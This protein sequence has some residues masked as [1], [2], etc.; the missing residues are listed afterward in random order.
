M[1]GGGGKNERFKKQ[2][3][4]REHACGE[5]SSKGRKSTNQNSLQ[6]AATSILDSCQP[7]PSDPSTTDDYLST[8]K[9]GHSNIL[10]AVRSR[11]L[12][13]PK[14]PSSLRILDQRLVILQDLCQS[15]PEEAFRIARSK[16]KTYAFD[17]AFDA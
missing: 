7:T 17:Y 12:S 15:R 3:K 5:G 1:I 6:M 9:H 14:D 11:P 16:E 13:S 10:V 8:L 2:P 4:Q